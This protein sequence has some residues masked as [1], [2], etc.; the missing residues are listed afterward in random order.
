MK[1]DVVTRD[2]TEYEQPTQYE[3]FGKGGVFKDN[4]YT[5][6]SNAAFGNDKS[7]YW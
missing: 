5:P 7:R 6:V 3:H 2:T 4:T 1:H